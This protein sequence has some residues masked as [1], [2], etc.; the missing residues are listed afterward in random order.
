MNTDLLTHSSVYCKFTGNDNSVQHSKV[1]YISSSNL[2]L[3]QCD[4]EKVLTSNTIQFIDIE[5]WMEP[6]E[7]HKF[8]LSSNNETYLIIPNLLNWKSNR[9]MYLNDRF[10]ILNYSIPYRKFNYEIKVIGNLNNY[11]SSKLDCSFEFGS[12]PN[13]SFPITYLNELDFVPLMLNFTFHVSHNFTKLTDFTFIE[14]SIFYRDLSFEHLK[15]FLVS[16]YESKTSK[17]HSITNM[18]H[19]LNSNQY[20]FDLNGKIIKVL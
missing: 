4:L 9:L 13:C 12:Y 18:N 20:S 1:S 15:P 16:Y 14:Y 10:M 6:S 11:S 7:T 2:K 19:Q 8:I 5:L 17:I 3:I